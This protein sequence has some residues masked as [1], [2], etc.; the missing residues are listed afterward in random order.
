MFL[1][2]IVPILTFILIHSTL[3]Q[4]IILKW[5][6]KATP[7]ERELFS[8]VFKLKREQNTLNMVDDFAKYSKIQRKINVIELELE[9]LKGNKN[10]TVPLGLAIKYGLKVIISLLLL[11]MSIYFRNTP[12]FTID[13]SLDLAP[14]NY[15]ISYPNELNHVSFHFWVICCT[16][17]A[18]LIK[19]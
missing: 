8:Q 6:K 14:F 13:K 18:E 2:F 11:I 4:S 9:E 3:F 17:M 7:K 15:I 1:L 16:S 10:T 19:L 5:W 12:V